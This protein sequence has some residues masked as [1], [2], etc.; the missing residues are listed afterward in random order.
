M[1]RF[2]TAIT[3]IDGRV[4]EP[5]T[6]WVRNRFLVDYVDMVTE[7]GADLVIAHG[8][9]DLVDALRQK[10]LISVNAH[11]S[12]VVAVSGHH[13]CA[14]HPVEKAQH[15]ADI[16]QAVQTIRGW[17]LSATLVGLWV[18]EDRTVEVVTQ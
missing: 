15:V 7:P 18:A 12:T 17:N 3:C 14:A 10:V 2:G 11:G 5:V 8:T 6:Q 4:Q 13:D 9:S 1:A 16:R